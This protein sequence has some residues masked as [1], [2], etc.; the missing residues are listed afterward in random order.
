[1]PA[2]AGID[3]RGAG[4]LH[5]LRLRDD[6]IPVVAVGHEVQ[7]RQAVDDDEFRPRGLADPADDLDGDPIT[8]GRISAPLV[9][10]P[11]DARSREFVDEVTFRSHDLDA[12]ITRLLRQTRGPHEAAD[13]ALDTPLR[14]GTRLE[15]VDRRLHGARR[16]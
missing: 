14:Q 11:V 10:S 2:D 3:Q 9:G 12:V 15:R 8:V 13:F 16:H 7:H 4:L 6:L 5:R 1:V